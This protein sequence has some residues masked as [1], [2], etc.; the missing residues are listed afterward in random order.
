MHTVSRILHAAPAPLALAALLAAGTAAPAARATPAHGSGRQ[1]QAQAGAALPEVF[2]YATGGTISN[3]QTGGRMTVEELIDSLP[4]LDRIARAEGEQ[5]ANVASGAMTTAMWLDLSRKINARFQSDADLAGVVVTSGTDTLEELAFFLH[6]TVRDP[7]P[8]VVVGSMRNP[9]TTG[10]EGVA[11]LEDGFRVAADPASRG[12]GTVVVLNDEINSAREAT[13]TDARLLNTFSSRGYGVLG[14]VINGVEYH[15]RPVRRHSAESEF[16]VEDIEAL[17]RVD[18]ILTYQ[19]AQGDLIEAAASLGAKG[20]VI[21]GAGAGATSGTQG[22]GIRNAMEQGVFIV[23]TTRTGAGSV[24]TGGR[25]RG[26]TSLRVGGGDLQPIKAR[27][28][29]MLALATT[30]DAD[31]VRRIFSEY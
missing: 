18:V 21:A 9:S 8:V 28:L 1:A 24:G 15:R 27:I 12:M 31:E 25:G 23:S 22:E 30:T 14:T 6:L 13:K 10:Y 3:R 17:P 19:E 5:F 20:I 26:G 29:L 2:F 16:R 4:N 11:N 7:R